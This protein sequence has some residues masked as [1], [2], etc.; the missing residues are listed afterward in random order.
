MMSMDGMPPEAMQ[1]ME[2]IMEGY[3]DLVARG[4]RE[5]YRIEG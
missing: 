2:A 5:I 4:K 1:K 3:H